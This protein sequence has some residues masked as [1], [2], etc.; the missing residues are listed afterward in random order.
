MHKSKKGHNSETTSPKERKTCMGQL[1][2]N[3]YFI[4]KIPNPITVLGCM[5]NVTN[6][7][8]LGNKFPF[9][10]FV[11]NITSQ[12]THTTIKQRRVNAD[13]TLEYMYPVY[14]IRV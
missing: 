10:L 9:L 2:F 6:G 7:R 8:N 11:S 1:I 12:H 4:Y 14:S 5:L 3:P 13:E